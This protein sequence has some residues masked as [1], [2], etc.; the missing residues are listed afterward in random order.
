MEEERDSFKDKYYYIAAELENTRKRFE[1]DKTNLVKFGNEKLISSLVGALD[2]LDLTLMAVAQEEDEKVKN[3]CVGVQMV[4]DQFFET[5]KQN[6]L[7]VIETEGKNFDPK[8]HEA[9]SQKEEKDVEPGRVIQ[10][11][12]KGYV[13]NG[14]VVRASKV[15]TSK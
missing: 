12:Q 6:G 14:R 11:V 5:L 15:I 9:I 10:E 4:R 3:I 8:F 2:N 1:R 7:E 13:L